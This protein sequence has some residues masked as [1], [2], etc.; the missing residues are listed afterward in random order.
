MRWPINCKR[1]V[2]LLRTRN[3][4]IYNSL[5][6][7]Y[8]TTYHCMPPDK[9]ASATYS[10]VSQEK[11]CC[12]QTLLFSYFLA[13]LYISFCFFLPSRFSTIFPLSCSK[14]YT[15][16]NNIMP[17]I[18]RDFS[19]LNFSPLCGVLDSFIAH[20]NSLEKPLRSKF[21]K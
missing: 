15:S 5:F 19:Y 2:R 12:L 10:S 4:Y 21:N 18:Q 17:C 1:V 3:I 6:L 11:A 13:A 7:Y 20:G 16:S 14:P 8:R 9:C